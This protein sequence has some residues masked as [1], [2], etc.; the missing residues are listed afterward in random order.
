MPTLAE[1]QAAA[2]ANDL[3]GDE[4]NPAALAAAEDELKQKNKK[5]Q[6]AKYSTY[7]VQSSTEVP[8]KG[9]ASAHIPPKGGRHG[10]LLRELVTEMADRALGTIRFR[11]EEISVDDL[12]SQISAEL[13]AGQATN[14]F[15]V[16]FCSNRL[17][18]GTRFGDPKYG[19]AKEK[20]RGWKGYA[21][22]LW[23]ARPVP[24][25]D[26]RRLY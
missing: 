21:G 15:D 13:L 1:L 12:K 26:P 23:I 25:P 10:S 9:Q 17:E 6:H 5:K 24:E 11:P 4:A 16:T 19:A 7:F 8:R 14:S 18:P 3:V 2:E 20:T 22:V